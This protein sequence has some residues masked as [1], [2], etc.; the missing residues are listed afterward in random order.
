[1]TEPNL[2]QCGFYKHAGIAGLLCILVFS[3]LKTINYVILSISSYYFRHALHIHIFQAQ[4]E[5]LRKQT[6]LVRK[7]RK[8]LKEKRKLDYDYK[9]VFTHINFYSNAII[10]L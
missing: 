5:L 9:R 7:E 4:L 8:L 10:I 6:K 3:G 2:N 1:M